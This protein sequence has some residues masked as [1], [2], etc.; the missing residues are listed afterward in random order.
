M[1]YLYDKYRGVVQLAECVVWDHEVAGS[2][3]A[4]PTVLDEDIGSLRL[5]VNQA[6]AGSIPV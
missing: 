6:S 3:P 1:L 4:T 2:S 5:T